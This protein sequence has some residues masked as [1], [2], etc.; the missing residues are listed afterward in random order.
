MDEGVCTRLMKNIMSDILYEIRHLNKSRT[1]LRN[2]T[3]ALGILSMGLS[4]L[5]W[6]KSNAVWP[7]WGVAGLILVLVAFGVPNLM[8]PFYVLIASVAAVIGYFLSRLILIV[9]FLILVT[10]I[11]LIMRL[12]G[13][14]PMQ[15]R[16]DKKRSS[17]WIE[18][19]RIS[20]SK[21]DYEKLF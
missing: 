14:D 6:M 3:L 9:I 8:M 12:I 2:F 19:P 7:L 1:A 5:A 17:Y 21:T 11:S 4:A 16:I 10:P 15:R 18:R 20:R 13:K